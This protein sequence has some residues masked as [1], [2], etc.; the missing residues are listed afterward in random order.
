[1]DK[2]L[3]ERFKQN[4]VSPFAASVTDLKGL[5]H[6]EEYFNVANDWYFDTFKNIEIGQWYDVANLKKP[7]DTQ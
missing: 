7:F 3:H 5:H 4:H 2:V 1:V 6:I